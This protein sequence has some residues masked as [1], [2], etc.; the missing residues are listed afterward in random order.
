M[1]ERALV[2]LALALAVD[3]GFGS[4]TAEPSGAGRR[5]DLV[6]QVGG[7]FRT[8][9]ATGSTAFVGVGSRLVALAVSPDGQLAKVG[10]LDLPVDEIIDLAATDGRLVAIGD[11]LGDGPDDLDL[12][13]LVDVA[14]PA[15]P[16]VASTVAIDHDSF[17]VATAGDRVVVAGGGADTGPSLRAFLV[18]DRGVLVPTGTLEANAFRA[19]AIVGDHAYVPEV[20]GRADQGAGLAVVDL[21][22]GMRLERLEL[23]GLAGAETVRISVDGSR[24][25]VTSGEPGMP[26]G[27]V[28][29]DLQVPDRPAVL[30]RSASLGA[31]AVL[32][33]DYV[34]ALLEDTFVVLDAD[35]L[36]QPG[37]VAELEA[38]ADFRDCPDRLSV[39]ASTG[40]TFVALCEGV[41]AIDVRQLEAPVPAGTWYGLGRSGEIPALRRLGGVGD[42]DAAS[43]LVA[44]APTNRIVLL[45]D[46]LKAPAVIAAP[47]GGCG[48]WSTQVALGD[49]L[50]FRADDSSTPACVEVFDLRSP[51]APVR[52]GAVENLPLAKSLSASGRR[53]VAVMQNP[54]HLDLP[55]LA[56]EGLGVIEVDAAGVVRLG[57]H[58]PLAEE[59]ADAVLVGSMAVV[60]LE[61]GT[62]RV[63][64][65]D[66]ATPSLLGSIDIT[67]SLRDVDFDGL[68]A[69]VAGSNGVSVID[70]TDRTRPLVTGR[71]EARRADRLALR[72]GRLYT[73]S[74]RTLRVFDVSDP[75]QPREL[76]SA[77]IPDFPEAIAVAG[78]R[79]WLAGWQTGLVELRLA[80]VDPLRAFLPLASR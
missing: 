68:T 57:A 48:F 70:L 45:S 37:F 3:A 9:A 46:G 26:E 67:G 22:R 49:G 78:D 71:P 12:L 44:G 6:R 4:G 76:A 27:T 8:L 77:S 51:D 34:L 14:D 80:L 58:L 28:L 50:L 10:G 75:S 62:V 30:G 29:V 65:V 11:P 2:V 16:S 54:G 1:R 24:A 19:V 59:I 56:A 13:F 38:G 74:G 21:G 72:D 79:V 69:A 43:T 73:A 42:V 40:G 66:A 41:V 15:A 7:E 31:S 64:D 36:G 18:S 20:D 60:G 5:L 61:E 53:A 23:P 33:G 39:A 35:Q 32:A 55:G 47:V 25:L 17:F 52:L 63:Y